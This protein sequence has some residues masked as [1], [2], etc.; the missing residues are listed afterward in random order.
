MRSSARHHPVG[1]VDERDAQAHRSDDAEHHE[2]VGQ[3][4]H[5]DPFHDLAS[6]F[7]GVA[8]TTLVTHPRPHDDEHTGEHDCR[9]PHDHRETPVFRPLRAQTCKP[10]LRVWKTGCSGRVKAQ[11]EGV[12]NPRRLAE[13]AAR[14]VI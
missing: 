9:Y 13:M 7:L 14:G 10:A 6:A 3:E 4:L 2:H 1:K 11:T 12:K 8:V 5:R